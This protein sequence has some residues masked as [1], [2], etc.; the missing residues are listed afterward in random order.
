VSLPIPALREHPEDI[1]LL[2][3]HFLRER[4]FAGPVEEFVDPEAM[5]HLRSHSWP[6]NVRELRNLIAAQLA[7]GESLRPDPAG[8][9]RLHQNGDAPLDIE[10]LLELPYKRARERLLHFFE[11]RYLPNLLEQTEGNIAKAAREAGMDRS[12]LFMLLRRHGL[13]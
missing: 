2:V 8:T 11:S 9:A 13:R 4:G 1:P 12:H 3:E 6:G 5:A 10:R 7:M